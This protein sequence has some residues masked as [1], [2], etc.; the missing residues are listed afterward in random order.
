MQILNPYGLSSQRSK[1]PDTLTSYLD[2]SMTLQQ[3]LGR[4]F[5]VGFKGDTL[6]P[7]DEIRRNIEEYRLGGVILFDRLVG[8]SRPTNNITGPEQ[9]R[10]LTTELQSCSEENLLIAVD[11]EGGK[12][13]R[14]KESAGFPVSPQPSYL[15]RIQGV[16]ATK[17]FALQTAKT[18][19]ESGVNWNL[20][21]VVDLEVFPENPII[22]RFGRSFSAAPEVVTAHA[23]AWV[24]AHREIGV[25]TSLK[26]FPGH[27]SSR[28][29]SHL[30]F[31]DI[32]ESWS[33][34]ELV[35]YR[36]LTKRDLADSIMLGHLYHR[37]FDPAEPA[38]LSKTIISG[39]IRDKLSYDGV[40]VT[41]DMQMSAITQR[42]DLV[43]A[44]C[45]ALAGGVD[46]IILGNNLNY[47]PKLFAHIVNKLTRRIKQGE[48]SE[49]RLDEASNRINRMKNRIAS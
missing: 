2:E 21:P 25:L 19:K 40:L 18:L 22:G 20:S 48:L 37:I 5:I 39:L 3:K 34:K 13:S 9:V 30:G 23:T 33:D 44:C 29:D 11:Q 7:D 10:R 38:T 16:Q 36:Q 1:N 31:V 46:M 4:L 35:P 28:T 42:Y 6:S 12:V 24:K 49:K 47:E 26:H 45:K 43:T 27:G 32:T 14:L 17:R 41:D 15:G 8:L